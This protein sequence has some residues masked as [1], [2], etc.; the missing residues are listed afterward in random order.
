[1][2]RIGLIFLFL[3]F[4]VI[5]FSLQITL[6]AEIMIESGQNQL[7]LIDFVENPDALKSFGKAD[8]IF[9]Y[10]PMPGRTMRVSKGYV[11][12]KFKR[13][14]PDAEYVLP[15]A[16]IITIYRKA[17]SIDSTDTSQDGFLEELSSETAREIRTVYDENALKK[18]IKKA[19]EKKLEIEFD[20]K[21]RAVYEQ[22]PIVPQT[23]VLE[24]IEI[25][26]RGSGKYM[27]RIEILDAG[28]GKR[29]ETAVF[30][31]SWPVMAALSDKLI[32]KDVLIVK[33]YVRFEEID[34]FD[35][36]NPVL[37]TS[38]PDDYVAD[39]N[40]ARD[41]VVEWNMLKKRSY[42]LKGQV[43]SALVQMDTVTIASQVEMLENAEIGQ[44]VKAR[45]LDS[46]IIITGIIEP[47][48]I[49]RVNY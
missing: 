25:Y 6:K 49:L 18:A 1:M 12:G 14:A 24:A 40:I 31:A 5:L 17:L 19:F 33:E 11:L 9:G 38:F 47:G 7:F 35:Y 13:Y 43:I 27:A 2:Y 36:K 46:G 10:S 20:E 28:K 32:G 48:P 26:S 30:T 29:Y 4:S 8:I 21:L 22:F 37:R 34:Y 41:R 23:G 42:V 44:I 39:Y 45:N 16:D 3:S 15:E